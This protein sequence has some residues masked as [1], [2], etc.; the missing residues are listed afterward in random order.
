LP[1]QIGK[2]GAVGSGVVVPDDPGQ[3]NTSVAI[4]AQMAQG[5]PTKPV[6]MITQ[7]NNQFVTRFI[8]VTNINS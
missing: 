2:W 4:I 7:P 3:S 6:K 8:T 5:K 1:N